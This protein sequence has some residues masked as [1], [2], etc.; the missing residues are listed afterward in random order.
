MTATDPHDAFYALRRGDWLPP[1]RFVI[2]ADQIARYLDATGESNPLWVDAAPPLALGAR[3]LAGMME[4]L[5]LPPGAV[6]G[7]QQFEFLR[8][9]RPATP[10]EETVLETTVQVAQRSER[11]GAVVLAFELEL[12]DVSLPDDNRADDRVDEGAIVARGRATVIGPAREDS[13]S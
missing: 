12:R 7:G 6:H 9:V 4:G 10:P 13:L 3:T 5:T 8:V 11:R 2:E 1:F